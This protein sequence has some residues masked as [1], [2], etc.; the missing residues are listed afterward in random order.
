MSLT[1]TIGESGA[2][3]KKLNNLREKR[4]VK[5]EDRHPC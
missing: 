4:V 1:P 2:Q 5:G 3:L